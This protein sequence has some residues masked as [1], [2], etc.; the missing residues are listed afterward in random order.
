MGPERL[1]RARTVEPIAAVTASGRSPWAGTVLVRY[2]PRATGLTA[3]AA[4]GLPGAAAGGHGELVFPAVDSAGRSVGAA[5]V[6]APAL[7]V[8][9]LRQREG[10]PFGRVP[11]SL[12]LS[13]APGRRAAREAQATPSGRRRLGTGF[14]KK[15]L[16]RAGRDAEQAPV[17]AGGRSPRLER[18]YALVICNV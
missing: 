12:R 1:D 4:V 14:K 2:P 15:G 18:L 11:A 6:I 17:G 16:F 13:P 8:S 3:G 9:E 7:P 5:G 10:A